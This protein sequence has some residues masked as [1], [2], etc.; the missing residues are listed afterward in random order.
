MSM[1]Y[2]LKQQSKYQRVAS[3]NTRLADKYIFDIKYVNVDLYARSPYYV[4][5]MFW[6]GLPKHTQDINAKMKFKRAIMEML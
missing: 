1:I 6:N 5:S 3:L 4:G 2:D